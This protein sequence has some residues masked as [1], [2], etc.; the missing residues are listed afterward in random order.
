[1]MKGRLKIENVKEN[2][3][4]AHLS[5]DSIKASLKVDYAHCIGKILSSLL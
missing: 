5:S 4:D 1:M 2:W 3:K